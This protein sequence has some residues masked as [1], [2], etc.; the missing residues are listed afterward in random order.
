MSTTS[1]AC[2]PGATIKDVSK[3]CKDVF[4]ARGL[5]KFMRHGPCHYIGLEV[6]DPGDT[7]K[8]FVPGMVFTVEP[9]LYDTVS[10]IGIRIEDVVAIT[11]DGCEVLSA[12][13]PKERAEVEKTVQAE[14]ILDRLAASGE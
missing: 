9:G 1:A 3:A 10:G 4:Q 12:L 14:G 5:D 8:V 11:A 6:H 2:K 13:A 7:K